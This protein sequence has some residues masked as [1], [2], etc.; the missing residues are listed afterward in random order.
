MATHAGTDRYRERFADGLSGGYFGTLDGVTL[1]SVGIGTYLGDPTD[2]ED[3]RYRDALVTAVE[4]G[5][6]VIDTAINYRCQ[7]SER[8][9]GRAIEESAVDRDEVFVATKGGYIP[10]DTNPPGHVEGYVDANFVETGLVDPEDLGEGL[11]CMTPE[12][13]DHQLDRSLSNLGTGTI[14]CY[15]VH[16]PEAQLPVRSREA[17]YDQLEATFARLESRVA[18]GDIERYGLATWAAFR[19]AAD[20]PSFLSLWEVLDRARAAADAAG[21]DDHHFRA[22]QLPFN[23]LMAEAF[24]V[25]SHETRDGVEIPNVLSVARANDVGVFTSASLGEGEVFERGIP[26]DVEIWFEGDTDAQKAINFARSAPGV[27]CAL[28]GSRRP[29]HVVENADAGTFDRMGDEAFDVVF[30]GPSDDDGEQEVERMDGMA[31]AGG[32]GA[33]MEPGGDGPDGGPL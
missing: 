15:Y 16:N 25:R 8:V 13:I 17:V 14:D 20:D 19:V 9:V 23:P 2:A 21:N 4:S 29:A 6:N 31:G 12:F 11:H 30:E 26:E 32:A 3:E 10:F 5:I 27:T 7:R 28:V 22:I 33:G 1:S 18:A 24:T